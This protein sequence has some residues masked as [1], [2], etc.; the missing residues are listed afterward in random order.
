[1]IKYIVSEGI[2][3]V[4]ELKKYIEDNGI[5]DD[6]TFGDTGYECDGRYDF[7]FT[8]EGPVPEPAKPGSRVNYL[9]LNPVGSILDKAVAEIYNSMAKKQLSESSHSLLKG[10]KDA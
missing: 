7:T 3:T 5:P 9:P 6:A 2:D 1:M 10:I 8:V 4:G